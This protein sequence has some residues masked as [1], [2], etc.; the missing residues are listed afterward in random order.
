[1]QVP[2][3]GGAGSKTGAEPAPQICFLCGSDG[4]GF[5]P[6]IELAP[7]TSEPAPL[8]TGP[9]PFTL[10]LAPPGYCNGIPAGQMASQQQLNDVPP[11]TRR[12]S[13]SHTWRLTT[14]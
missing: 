13:A 9:A 14:V 6:K 10:E 11:A 3:A 8:T 2:G 4:A 5:G 12:R 1:M 7:L